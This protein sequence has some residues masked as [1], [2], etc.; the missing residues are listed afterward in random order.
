[1]PRKIFLLSPTP[2]EGV[3]NLAMITFKTTSDTLALEDRDL[4]IFTS[5]QA[6]KSAYAI[7]PSFI[8][9]PT[10]SIGKATS[11][12]L[13]DLGA[14]VVHSADRFYGEVLIQDIQ[15]YFA[16]RKLLYLRPQKVSTDIK[17]ALKDTTID[18]QEQIIYQTECKHYK[19][20]DKPPKNSI[21]IFTSPSTIACF[22]ENFVWESSYTAV[23]IGKATLKHLP[24]NAKYTVASEP[25]IDACIAK[26][27]SIA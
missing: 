10:L 24:H 8:K 18:I 7:N 19:A 23:I 26:A 2:F 15:S 9:T 17:K 14:N 4:L 6:V 12:V 11:K 16:D 13:K 5:K 25:L 21:I 20:K 22:L 27:L 1:M 3:E